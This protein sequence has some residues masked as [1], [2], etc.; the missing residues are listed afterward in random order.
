MNHERPT[1]KDPMTQK[2]P[3]IVFK[4][5]R[6]GY[7][8]KEA[9]ETVVNDWLNRVKRAGIGTILC[10]LDEVQLGY[11]GSIS[12]GLLKFYEQAGFVVIH[13][14]VRDHQHP[15]VPNQ[16]LQAVLSDFENAKKPV[17][18][19]CSAGIDRTGAVIRFLQAEIPGLQARGL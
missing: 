9:G 17:L 18:V 3:E 13:R 10:L 19:H 5:S 7:P 4:S 8:S 11:Y 16:I 6:P 14:P 12:G 1:P 2:L 15:P